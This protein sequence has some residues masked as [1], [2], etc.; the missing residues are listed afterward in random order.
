MLLHTGVQEY[1]SIIGFADTDLGA[2]SDAGGKIL[3]YHGLV[4]TIFVA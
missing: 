3:V 1:D 2:F 4:R